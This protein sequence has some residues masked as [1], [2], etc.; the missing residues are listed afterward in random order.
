MTFA[1]KLMQ[2]RKQQGWSQEELA[3]R[4][5]VTRQSVSKWEGAQS[6]PELEK[7]VALSRLFGVS[8][9]YLLKDKLEGPEDGPELPSP[10]APVEEEV[11]FRQVS[12][13]EAEAFLAI[14]ESGARAIAWGV[15]LCIYSPMLLI[16]LAA[17]SEYGSGSFS[18]SLAVGLGMTALLVMV[19][20]AVALFISVGGKSAPFE[21]L[22]KEPF[23]TEPG[24]REMAEARREQCRDA[25]IRHNIL[26]CC[27]CVLSAIPLMF[28][29]MTERAE[30]FPGVVLLLAFFLIV[31]AGVFFLVRGGVRWE[32]FQKLL[33]EGDYT[34]EKK[35]ASH[36][37]SAVYWSVVT[38]IYLA[39][40]L[41]TFKWAWSWIIWCVAAVLY[42]AV[43][44]LASA[45]RK[46]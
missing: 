33:Q 22:E 43:V 25:Y 34:R 17:L 13:G 18:P 3:Q 35:S 45:V 32:S 46:R 24:V 28:L 2:L 11:L 21:Y 29:Y 39:Y 20:G 41:I 8:T 44:A 42:P 15:L 36:A 14:R 40:S 38:A 10:S 23:D 16:F 7:I 31:G 6:V 12:M 37:L 19:A 26:G 9:D 27:L 4:L 30:D 1:D 5:D